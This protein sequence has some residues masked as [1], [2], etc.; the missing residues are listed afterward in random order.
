VPENKQTP[1]RALY[2]EDN[3]DLREVTGLLVAEGG[4]T[5]TLCAT[6]ELALQEFRP[7]AYDLV[8]TDIGLPG[9]SGLEL[10][11]RILE[12]A[13]DTRL[14]FASVMDVDPGRLKPNVRVLT[15][16][17]SAEDLKRLAREM[18]GD[19]PQALD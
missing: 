2:V 13:P 7:G 8:I 1:L 10:A 16:P 12:M 6:A 11:D 18:V 4:V 3:D 15:K 17:F 5:V 14:V 9:I 19:H